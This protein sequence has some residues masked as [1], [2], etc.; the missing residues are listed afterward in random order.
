MINPKDDT[1]QAILETA[2]R[3]AERELTDNTYERDRYPY[4][5]YAH[6]AKKGAA[7]A[8]LLLLGAPEDVGGVELPAE[9]WALVLEVVA[10][11]DA[12]F[13]AS[14]MAHAM[15]ARALTDNGSK[16]LV[17]EVLGQDPT[18]LLAHPIYLQADD[19]QGVPAAIGQKDGFLLAG[20]ARMAANAPVA[21]AAVLVA[22][23]GDG[24]PA[25]FLVDLDGESRPEPSEMLGLRA[26]PVGH[27]D[28]PDSF[29]PA[30]R[31]LAKGAGAIAKLHQSFYPAAA[32]ILIGTLKSSVDYAIG[33]GMERYQG[34]KNIQEHSQ[35][36][37][38]YGR[39]TAEAATLRQ[40][41]LAAVSEDDN[42]HDRVSLKVM[43][44]DLAV[45]ATM[46]GVQ[47][48]GGY[49]YTMEYPQERKMRDARQAAEILGSPARLRLSMMEQIIGS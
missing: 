29:V 19:V 35:L 3:F 9:A 46:D 25:I 20:Q 14:L 28:L 34:G 11:H 13:A 39:M 45:R 31:M 49:G 22:E 47:L 26:C 8:G 7:D 40:A 23:L 38:M 17:E 18:P 30:E 16:K 21:D 5:D 1:L 48:L 2:A 37:S 27:I 42:R 4:G 43:A 12:G 6:N 41:M 32:A 33:Y 36:R 15:A 44:A 24:E 10:Y